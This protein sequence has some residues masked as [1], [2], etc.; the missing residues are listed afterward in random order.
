M[1]GAAVPPVRDLGHLWV[2]GS[3]GRCAGNEK[4]E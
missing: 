1:G 4:E 2:N 3:G